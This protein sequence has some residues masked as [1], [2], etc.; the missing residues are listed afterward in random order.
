[1]SVYRPNYTPRER[2]LFGEIATAEVA[3]AK[4]LGFPARVPGQPGYT[5]HMETFDTGDHSIVTLAVAAAEA[6]RVAEEEG[7]T[8]DL[9]AKRDL[10]L[11]WAGNIEE[12]LQTG[13]D[14]GSRSTDYA[15]GFADGW[16]HALKILRSLFDSAEER[17]AEAE[18]HPP[19]RPC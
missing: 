17:L 19:P 7:K 6:L 9:K 4:A 15:E 18:S 1:M 12:W 14:E 13:E 3:L 10:A 8:S 2:A 5:P 11:N 16:S